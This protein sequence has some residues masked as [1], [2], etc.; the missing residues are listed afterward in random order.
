M[1]HEL[2]EQWAVVDNTHPLQAKAHNGERRDYL[3]DE[4]NKAVSKL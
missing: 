4:V 2:V 3:F 1:Q